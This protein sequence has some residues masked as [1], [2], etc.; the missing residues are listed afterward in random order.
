[1]QLA[2]RRS[3]RPNAKRAT[4]AD[5]EQVMTAVAECFTLAE[6]ALT[7]EVARSRDALRDELKRMIDDAIAASRPKCGKC[8]TPARILCPDCE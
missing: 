2:T 5:I 7:A 3:T 4:L 8:G 1:M 6:G